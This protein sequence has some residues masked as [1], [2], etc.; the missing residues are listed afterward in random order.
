[1][2]RAP[3]VLLRLLDRI[4]ALRERRRNGISHHA[5]KERKA[6]ELKGGVVQGG[7]GWVGWQGR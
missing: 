3:E 2:A 5:L 7:V 6:A 1:M 4:H